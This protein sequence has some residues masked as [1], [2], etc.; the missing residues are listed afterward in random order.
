[1][2]RLLFSTLLLAAALLFTPSSVQAAPIITVK[3]TVVD[4]LQL[5]GSFG[6]TISVPLG[7]PAITLGGFQVDLGIPG[8]SSLVTFTKVDYPSNYVFD[9][10]SLNQLFL[11]PVGTVTADTAETADASITEPLGGKTINPGQ[12]YNLFNVFFDLNPKYDFNKDKSFNGGSVKVPIQ[13]DIVP[14]PVTSLSD[15]FGDP[16]PYTFAHGTITVIVPEPTSFALVGL[17]G[18]AV[19]AWHRRRRRAAA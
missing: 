18:L 9:F 8:G 1:M 19:A 7:D 14:F 13:L 15:Q 11:Q 5:K 10:P 12:T 16:I 3:S 17:T 6:V 4:Y 2:K